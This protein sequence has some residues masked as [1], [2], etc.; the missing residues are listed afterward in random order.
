MYRNNLEQ[1][2]LESY[3]DGKLDKETVEYIA[4]RLTRNKLKQYI[5]LLKEEERKKIVFVTTPK[6]LTEDDR[7]KI[8]TL[9]P[10]KAIIEDIDPKM[11]SGIKLVENDEEYEFNLNQ[12]FHDIIRFVSNND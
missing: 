11:I 4:D 6:P 8:S 12:T 5:N 3:K 2:V 10:K 9:F 1:L 7:K